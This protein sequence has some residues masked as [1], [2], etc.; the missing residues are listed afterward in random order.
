MAS[1][2]VSPTATLSNDPFKL[3]RSTETVHIDP[4]SVHKVRI[5]RDT[6]F[7]Q[8]VIL[9]SAVPETEQCYTSDKVYIKDFH[10][11]FPLP[12]ARVHLDSPLVQEATVGVSNDSTL[13]IPD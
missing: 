2:Q 1:I 6:A 11:P 5:E 4:N 8:S 9:K 12:L 7:A 3:F 13:P 10:Q